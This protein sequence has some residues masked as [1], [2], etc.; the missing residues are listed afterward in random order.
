MTINIPK[1]KVMHVARQEK[2]APPTINEMKATEAKY[3]HK[4]KFCPRRCKTAGGLAKH[5]RFCNFQHKLSEEVFE[6][7]G[8]NAVF[9][10]P[11]HRWFRVQWRGYPGQDSWEP[12]RSL[13]DQGC[14]SSIRDFWK[15]SNL[16]PSADFYADPDDIWRCYQCGKGYAGE[17]Y[18]KAH[19]T[20]THP[21]RQWHGST[22][23]RE[24]RH[25]KQV[26]AQASKPT[27]LCEGKKLKN[28]WSFVYLGSKFSVDGDH[29][30]DVRARV[31]MARKTAGKMRNI[32]SSRWIPLALKLRIYI[33][34]V[35]SVLVYGSEA[36]TLD[37]NAIRTINGANSIMLSRISGKSVHDEARD[38]TRSF[39]LVRWIRARRAQYLGHILGM[40]PSRI[41]HKAV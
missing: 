3:T 29:M 23:D 13:R 9:G 2:I 36:W 18:L 24:T 26:A 28:V 20:R 22:V 10:V 12:E 38:S 40:D 27:I 21:P 8:I 35:C 15:Q 7:E 16:N 6:V 32:W 1:T 33:S 39:D 5:M 31:A 41:V 19:I 14:G 17:R 30:T 4:C 37:A 11:E 25:A 34:G